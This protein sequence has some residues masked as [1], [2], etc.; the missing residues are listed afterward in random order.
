MLAATR[1]RAWPARGRLEPALARL[2]GA[3]ARLPL[4]ARWRGALTLDS[5]YLRAGTYPTDIL[6]DCESALVLFGAA[7]LGVNDAIHV[8]AAGLADV[9]VVDTD[10]EKL[11][12]MRVLYP[13]TWELVPADAFDFV[14]HRRAAG[15]RYDVVSADPFTNLMPRCRAELS[16]LCTLARHAVVLGIEHGL[17][18]DPPPGWRSRRIERS[19]LADWIVLEAG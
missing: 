17:P 6:G 12:A 11:D 2:L 7:F 4:G 3:A 13:R 19:E 15:A 8:A 16:S 14:E 18:F 5:I 1:P 10:P 9:T